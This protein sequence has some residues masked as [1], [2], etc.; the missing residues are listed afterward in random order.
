V[1]QRFNRQAAFR[2]QSTRKASREVFVIG[3]EKKQ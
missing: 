2:P 1:K 3:I